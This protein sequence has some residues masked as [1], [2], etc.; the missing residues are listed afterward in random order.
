[1][2]GSS[3]PKTAA[4]RALAAA[5]AA[6]RGAGVIVQRAEMIVLPEPDLVRVMPAHHDRR[7]ILARDG[8][9]AGRW[10][11]LLHPVAQGRHAQMDGGRGI[12]GGARAR[13]ALVLGAVDQ[14][15]GPGGR[16]IVPVVGDDAGAGGVIAGQDG[17]VAGA[18]LGRGMALEA[19]G[20]DRAAR[21]ALHAG[22]V[23]RAILREEVG[24]EL[25]D[26]DRHQQLR[27]GGRCR[28]GSA[29][30]DPARPWPPPANSPLHQL[31]TPVVRHSRRVL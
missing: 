27:P 31:L 30:P 26:G 19:R 4:A 11:G 9:D 1:M 17:G 16:Q 23:G 18:G 10:I 24:G 20:K 3:R 8:D 22:G 6:G 12:S 29:A 5:M 14:L 28:R 2:F 7:A 21:Q 25:I 15:V 13:H